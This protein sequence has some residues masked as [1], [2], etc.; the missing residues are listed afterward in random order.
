MR[1][2]TALGLVGLAAGTWLLARVER[3]RTAPVVA[4]ELDL[5]V[6]IPA[7]DEAASLPR[8]LSSL[9]AQ[10]APAARIIVVDDESTDGTAAVAR[11][12][13]VEVVAVPPRPPGW[14]GKAWACWSGASLVTTERIAFVDADT[15]LAPAALG[16][17]IADHTEHGGLVSVQPHHHPELPYEQLSLFFNVVALMGSGAFTPRPAEPV[18]AFGPCLVCRRTDYATT[19]GHRA[20]RGEV[21]EDLGVARE[22][23]AAG[24]PVRVLAGGDAV[25]FRM[26]PGGLATLVEGWTKNFATGATGVRPAESALVT[27]WIAGLAQIAVD[28]V[29]RRD[30]ES[31][32]L[33]ALAVA[34]LSGLARRAGAFQPWSVALYPVPLATFMGVFARSLALTFGRGEVTWRGRSIAT[35]RRTLNGAR[36]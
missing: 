24:L 22:F 12:H 7:R 15:W 10:V 35:T 8:L 3:L 20:V 9:G 21:A 33:Y 11:A 17:L 32:V 23:R 28:L 16:N 14:T 1:R 25:A 4:G 27:L 29:R 31:A 13:E 34:Q 36:S 26:Y 2:G 30:A 5:T 18:V 6:V 19:D